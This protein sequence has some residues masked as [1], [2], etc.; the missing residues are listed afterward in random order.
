M[1]HVNNKNINLENV[2][3]G[4]SSWDPPV[5]A[6][7]HIHT[8]GGVDVAALFDQVQVLFIERQLDR[9]KINL[10]ESRMNSSMASFDLKFNRTAR[11][12]EDVAVFL[13]DIRAPDIEFGS[14]C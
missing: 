12:P 13:N 2:Y 9:E 14:V 5:T 3:P 11:E 4:P 7:I 10:F 1:E 8:P 6:S